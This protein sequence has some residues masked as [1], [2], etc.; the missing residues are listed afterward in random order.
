MWADT[1][2]QIYTERQ[3]RL[4][5][6]PVRGTIPLPPSYKRT[7]RFLDALEPG[8]VLGRKHLPTLGQLVRVQLQTLLLVCTLDV[9]GGAFLKESGNMGSLVGG[10]LCRG[11]TGALHAYLVEIQQVVKDPRPVVAPRQER[12][13][14][15]AEEERHGG[16]P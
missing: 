15:A 10:R 16:L 7:V 3:V 12:A 11:W 5:L 13:A 2:A 6:I 1:D 14:T 8:L 9:L 4:L